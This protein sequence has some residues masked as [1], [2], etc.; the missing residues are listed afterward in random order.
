MLVIVVAVLLT[1]EG[2][3]GENGTAGSQA[4][5]SGELLTLEDV[6]EG[7]LAA[8]RF[9]GSWLSANEILYRDEFETSMVYNVE[10][11]NSSVLLSK[12]ILSGGLRIGVSADGKYLLIA[13][14]VEKV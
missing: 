3:N 12:E 5:H 7:K 4:K 9:N 11:G 6:L 10:S 2:S 13:H 14:G 1:N 8:R